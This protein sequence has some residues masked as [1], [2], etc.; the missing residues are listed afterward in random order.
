MKRSTKRKPKKKKPRAKSSSEPITSEPVPVLPLAASAPLDL[1]S[2]HD[3]GLDF[4]DEEDEEDDDD[5]AVDPHEEF[6]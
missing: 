1:D 6:F 3:D 5:I 2:M 4:E